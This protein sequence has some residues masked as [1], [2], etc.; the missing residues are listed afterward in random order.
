MFPIFT[1]LK[2]D[3]DF[4]L[5]DS[6][7][8]YDPQM[9]K[10]FANEFNMH[11]D[12][13][14]NK[15]KYSGME[16][17]GYFVGELERF[18]KKNQSISKVVVFGDTLTTSAGSIVAKMMGLELFHIEAGLR[19]FNREMPEE[20]NRIIADHIAD[21]NLILSS[22][23]KENLINEGIEKQ[24]IIEIGDLMHDSVMLVKQ[25][26]KDN[27][28]SQ[29]NYSLL[30]IHRKENLSKKVTI[31]AIFRFVESLEYKFILP[32]HHSLKNA[33]N[34]YNLEIPRNVRAVNPLTYIE[35]IKHID[36]SEI[37]LTDSGGLQK[38]AY[39]CHKPVIVLR[40]ET[41]WMELINN[42]YS[43]YFSDYKKDH[44]FNTN[45]ESLY[46]VNTRNIQ[47][48]QDCLS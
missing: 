29:D 30:T 11:P 45:F 39:Y 27:H 12:Y 21:K 23:G 47:I 5:I 9:S 6:G 28:K 34:D 10:Q 8:H 7:Q 38:E 48:I 20:I 42:N 35:T 26:M 16:F 17:F 22:A 14:F 13:I 19:S 4:I 46:Y 40:N 41:E 37:V 15:S 44:K 1:H 33:M 25:I 24:K 31:E 18:L 32:I 36:N 3:L 2:D 43:V